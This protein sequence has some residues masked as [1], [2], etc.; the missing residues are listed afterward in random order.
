MMNTQAQFTTDLPKLRQMIES[1][2][3]LHQKKGKP[4]PHDWLAHHYESGQTFR[5]YY[6]SNPVRPF[7]KRHVIYIQPLGEFTEL[8][9]KIVTLTA[10]FMSRFYNLEVKIKK[11][12]PLSIIPNRAKRRHPMWG[13]EQILTTYVLDN[14]LKPKLPADAA[15]YLAFTTSD[16][17]PGKGWNFVFGQASLLERVGVWSIYRNGNP[18]EGNEGFKTCL[19]R[20]LKTAVHEM[21]HMFSMAHCIQYECGMCGSNHREESDR[22][23]L[24]FCPECIAK[25]CWA[26]NTD[27][28]DRF[29]TLAQFCREN[30]LNRE[31]DFYEKSIAVL[32]ATSGE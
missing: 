18:A 23:P 4:G 9:R 16:L 5:E 22:R 19:V 14:I 2:R 21:G 28:I 13:M 30:G 1:L 10:D 15:A 8:E 29:H 24:W 32:N 20:T 7:G 26:T 27:P 11:D 3:P 12:I 6:Q 17:W 25:V 31:K